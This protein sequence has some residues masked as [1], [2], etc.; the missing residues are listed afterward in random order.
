MPSQPAAPQP[1]PDSVR[2]ASLD[3]RCCWHHYYIQYP[4]PFHEDVRCCWCGTVSCL[5]LDVSTP[6]GHGPHVDVSVQS[7]PTPPICPARA[8]A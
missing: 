3:D 6:P 5:T 7:R 2:R 8:T 4:M 1:S